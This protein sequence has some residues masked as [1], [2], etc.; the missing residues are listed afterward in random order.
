MTTPTQISHRSPVSRRTVMGLAGAGAGALILGTSA[1]G[2]DPKG[3]GGL[4]APGD[5]DVW[6]LQDEAQNAV[7]NGAVTRFNAAHKAKAKITPFANDPY[8]DRLRVAM[9]SRTQPDIFFNWGS[10]SIREYVDAGLLVDLTP[11]LNEDAAFKAK[12]I[13]SVLESGKIGGAFY[14]IPNR[15]MQPVIL[16]YNK[17]VLKRV[18]VQQPPATWSQMLAFVDE[19]KKAGITPFAVA[20]SQ[21]WTLLMWLEYFVDRLGGPQPFQRIADGD[22][23][24]WKDPAIAGAIDKIRELVDRGGFASNFASVGYETGGSGTLF[25]QGRAAMH[26]MGSW[27]YTNQV[28]E[29]PQFARSALGF[30]TFPAIEGGTGNPKAIVGNPTNYFSVTKSSDNVEAS[31]AFLKEMASDA[32]VDDYIGRGDVPAIADIE[33]RFDRSPSPEFARFV[34]G[35]VRDASSF[36][37]SWDQAIAN[38]VAQPMLTNLQKV[39]LKQLDATGFVTAMVNLK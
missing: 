16:Y 1:C 33:S 20:G 6:V 2:D 8:R 11:T 24:G 5:L 32:Y 22:S 36:Q 17:D 27:E 23:D 25:A 13:P 7:Q 34:Y 15:G 31:I 3:G 39:F 19:L 26:L 30:A 10:G 37:L 35:M 4:E 38:R 29:Q 9:G 28:R 12:W 21:T 18:G 14:G